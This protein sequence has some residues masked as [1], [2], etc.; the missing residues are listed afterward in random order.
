LRNVRI[1]GG[2]P[3]DAPQVKT[4][5]E[6]G[7]QRLGSGGRLSIRPS[8]T[9][10]LIRVMAQ[11]DDERLVSDVVNEIVAALERVTA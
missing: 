6:N 2:R 1:G 5:I 9:E 11:G 7:Q 10:P 3:L 4:A 8:G